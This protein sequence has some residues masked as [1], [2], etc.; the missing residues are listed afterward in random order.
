MFVRNEQTRSGKNISFP[1]NLGVSVS[2]ECLNQH[3]RA[4]SAYS[5]APRPGT[6][7]KL[8]LGCF[9][10]SVRGWVC[11]TLYAEVGRDLPV[12]AAQRQPLSLPASP[13]FRASQILI[14]PAW[15]SVNIE[16]ISEMGLE[17]ANLTAG[18]QIQMGES[19]SSFRS[20]ASS[21]C[22]SSQQ[23]PE[24]PTLVVGMAKTAPEEASFSPTG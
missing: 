8:A 3:G 4:V 2:P 14:D 16:G 9:W 19:M 7:G 17:V 11:P 20:E 24:E 5:L 1:T 15:D 22:S 10:T 23:G 13:R 18:C 12:P 6:L 21:S